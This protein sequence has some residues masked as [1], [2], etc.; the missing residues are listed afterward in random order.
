MDQI[1]V[2][3]EILDDCFLSIR[4]LINE[5]NKSNTYINKN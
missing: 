1:K 3:K 5:Q 4:I 2:R